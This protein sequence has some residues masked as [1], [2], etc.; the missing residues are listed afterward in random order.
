MPEENPRVAFECRRCEQPA[1]FPSKAALDHHR[2]LVHQVTGMIKENDGIIYFSHC[3]I[4]IRSVDHEFR[5]NPADRRFHCPHCL[6]WNS[7]YVYSLRR[8]LKKEH[9]QEDALDAEDAVEEL[10]DDNEAAAELARRPR[11]RNA[12]IVPDSASENGSD[13]IQPN[14]RPIPQQDRP[15]PP[16]DQDEIVRRQLVA[17]LEFRDVAIPDSSTRVSQPFVYHIPS[18]LL[19]CLTH[20]EA[21]HV[22]RMKHHCKHIG[23]HVLPANYLETLTNEIETL[24]ISE[25]ERLNYLQN[26]TDE[27]CMPIVN[28]KDSF[29]CEA[30]GCGII[31]SEI[32]LRKHRQTLPEAQKRIHKSVKCSAIIVYEKDSPRKKIYKVSPANPAQ[33]QPD[34]DQAALRRELQLF[35]TRTGS[36]SYAIDLLLANLIYV[37][38]SNF[39]Q[40]ISKIRHST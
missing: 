19:I 39:R 11:I 27:N 6:D 3:R 12:E 32:S 29:H 15:E 1:Y 5:R 23:R 38:L 40:M 25:E 8:H 13:V 10:S 37:E 2:R 35:H 20:R 17:C 30:P 16:P 22:S 9:P 33:P 18:G 21:F 24:Q 31:G 14:V 36:L 7:Q 34:R 4:L 28:I 26:M